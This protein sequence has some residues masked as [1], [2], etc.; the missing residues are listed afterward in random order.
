MME[1]A[2]RLADKGYSCP[3]VMRAM[4]QTTCKIFKIKA[5]E[6]NRTKNPVGSF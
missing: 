4:I 5:D 3:L 6:N 2:R 1:L